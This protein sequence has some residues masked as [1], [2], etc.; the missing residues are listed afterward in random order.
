MGRHSVVSDQ[1]NNWSDNRRRETY[2]HPSS[3]AKGPLA[4]APALDGCAAG[5]PYRALQALWKT[6]VPVFSRPG[7]R[8]EV[9][10]FRESVGGPARDGL[11]PSTPSQEGRVAL[12]QL[13]PGP[14]D[15]QRGVSGQPRTSASQGEDVGQRCEC[16]NAR[17]SNAYHRRRSVES[18]IGQHDRGL[19]GTNP[20]GF[21]QRRGRC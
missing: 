7:P 10:S 21:D 11:R 14:G 9:L 8:A 20:G 13:P 12:G 1:L 3:K 19:A 17:R 16:R 15:P 18:L 2:D 6:G 4:E 5:I